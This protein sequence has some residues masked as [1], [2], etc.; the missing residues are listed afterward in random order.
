MSA[1]L[2]CQGWG[3]AGV[4]G[5][6][7]HCARG[8]RAPACDPAALH[9]SPNAPFFPPSCLPPMYAAA[10][11]PSIEDPSTLQLFIDFYTATQAG[12]GGGG[13]G[14]GTPGRMPVSEWACK[15][16]AVWPAAAAA[17]THVPRS[18]VTH[19]TCSLHATIPRHP[20]STAAAV[21]H[22]AGVPGA[23]R[24]G[25]PLALQLRGRAL[26]VPQQVRGGSGCIGCVSQP[27]A[28]LHPTSPRCLIPAPAHPPCTA[29]HPAPP[30][31]RLVNGTRDLLRAQAGL[32][33]H[34]NY[35]EF[36]RLL[37]RLKANYQLSELVRSWA[38]GGCLVR[39][40]W[41]A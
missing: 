20:P 40:R 12:R 31:R 30:R 25:A 9:T 37:G 17:G 27:V 5:R 7:L 15:L 26:R 2:C 3:P 39:G 4:P 13:G 8:L 19:L 28:S 11:R 14:L 10:W 24:L 38:A 34:A 1:L 16:P 22:G 32:A 23:P 29:L 21:Q 36:C 41:N 18:L 6:L 35:H 33:H